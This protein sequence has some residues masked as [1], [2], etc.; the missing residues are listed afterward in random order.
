MQTTLEKIRRLEQYIASDDATV[1]PVVELAIDK[2]L[3]RET[4]RL[5]ELKPRLTEQLGAFEQQYGLVSADFYT[6]YSSGA[7]G[8][9]IDFIEWVATVEMLA[10][11]EKGMLNGT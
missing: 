7:M 8:D 1:D 5:L 3:E 9:A 2:L 11:I 6:R 10:N 4:A